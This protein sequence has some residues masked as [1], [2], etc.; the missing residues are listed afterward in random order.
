[1]RADPTLADQV[2]GQA[3]GGHETI[4]ERTHRFAR[5]R[6][7][8]VAHLPRHFQRDRHRFLANH[9]LAM[10][11]GGDARFGM[12]RVGGAI[13]ENV[14]PRVGGQ[15][16]PIGAERLVAVSGGLLLG[17]LGLGIAK[18]GQTRLDLRRRVNVGDFL[19]GIGVTLAHKAASQQ[20]DP[21]F[22]G[23]FRRCV[24]RR[25]ESSCSYFVGCVKHTTCYC[26]RCVS[27]TLLS[28]FYF[29]NR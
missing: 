17:Q 22:L 26:D 19:I 20:T 11:Q 12:H 9:V 7:G 27:R 21:N 6:G 1:M 5:R 4:V 3:H 14:D 24:A 18:H 15:V 13:V 23:G 10:F 8:R 16:V 2:F 28:T 29:A 25:H